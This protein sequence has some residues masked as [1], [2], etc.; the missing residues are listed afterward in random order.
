[1]HHHHPFQESFWSPTSSID[2]LP[3]YTIGF[4]VLHDKLK[5]SMSENKVIIEYIKQRIAAEKSHALTLSTLI[6]ATNNPFDQDIGG[7][8][9]RCFEVV[10]SE[11]LESS[12]E[13]QGRAEDLNTTAL[14]PLS[15][16]SARYDRIIT[17]A[18]ETVEAQIAHFET[19]YKHM[20]QAKTLYQ[21]R[22]KALLIVQP[23]Y[24]EDGAS[25]VKVG[26]DLE[27]P[28][29]DHVWIWLQ[30]IEQENVIMTRDSVLTWLASKS[31]M[32]EKK[33]QDALFM[34]ENLEKMDFIIYEEE[35]EMNQAENGSSIRIKL[36]KP[37]TPTSE[38]KGF[39]GFL[40]RWSSNAGGQSYKRIEL[41]SDML[42]ADKNY[43]LSVEKV[44]KMR[45]Q[46][47]QVLFLHYDEM[48]SLE[49][50]RIQTIKQGK[51]RKV[52]FCMIVVLICSI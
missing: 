14:D 38:N 41:V 16:F 30:E 10:Y 13:H 21:N 20:E 39:A 17:Q 40:G 42:E 8:L 29:R 35:E 18:K 45:T 52:E 28:T 24:T 43:R 31:T 2:A 49:L 25:K 23:Q 33:E 26:M 6:P 51:N 15:K 3:N 19:L 48:E 22:C 9:K 37:G 47:E 11:S 34:L 44:E 1:M 4:K 32:T 36:N 5:Q 27:F 7:G 46:V 12:K 50:E